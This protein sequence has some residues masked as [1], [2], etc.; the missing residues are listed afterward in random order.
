MERKAKI[1]VVD[2]EPINLKL[3]EAILLLE[4]YEVV[5]A[6]NGEEALKII[7][8]DGIELALLDVMM[9]GVDGFEVTKQV[10]QDSTF[11]LMPI[12]LVTALKDTQDRIKGIE[13]GC[14]D[15]ISK[16][17][18]KQEVL[19]RVK[20][21]LKLSFYRR[22]LDQKEKFETVIR[23]MGEGVIICGPDWKVQEINAAAKKYLN[24]NDA[25]AQNL[26]ELIFNGYSVS[27]SKE[28]LMNLSLLHKKFDVIREESEQFKALYLEAELDIFKNPLGE[29]SSIIMLLRDV[30]DKHREE[31]MKQDFL[32][33]ISHK[34]STPLNVVIQ[35][36]FTMQEGIL[37]AL[38]E[39]QKILV[40][41]IIQQSYLLKNII[42]RLVQ[43]TVL[44]N[45]RLDLIKEEIILDEYLPR[46]IDSLIKLVKDRKIDLAIDCPDK[47]ARLYMNKVYFD[48]V[49]GNLIEN[50]IKFNDKDVIK[51][52]IKVRNASDQVE[53]LIIDNGR[54]I[55]A[56]YK[57]KIFEKFYQ[58]EKNFTGQVEGMGI[59]LALIRRIISA[60]GGE[61][62]LESE[63]NKGTTFKIMF[64]KQN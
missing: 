7:R 62:V 51:I 63:I 15:F 9:P 22:Q 54:G 56:E 13:A 27:L 39:K 25:Q 55:P 46:L 50:A 44:N 58:I 60:Y 29:V 61:L 35:N 33:F 40:S 36:G 11:G 42:S 37:G 31:L 16:P 30:T 21:L 6:L 59:G 53:I 23:Q 38:N 34:L 14:D 4:G 45:Q 2:D 28:E 43:F 17:F 48:Q 18:D 20:T 10:R 57:D 5:T 49:I 41:A 32:S 8:A 52:D 26:I 64:P 1:L 12:V 24:C 19:A 47:N 3:L